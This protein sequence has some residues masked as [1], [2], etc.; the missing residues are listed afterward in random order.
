[1]NIGV[2]GTGIVG[3]TISAHLAGGGH[4]VVIGTR[5][6]AH[7]L[8]QSAPDAMGTPPFSAW[9]GSHA[10]VRLGTF[11]EAAAH[12]DVLINATVGH[13]SLNALAAAGGDALAGKVLLDIA[14]PLDFSHGMPPSLF[15]C[16][17]D[18][19]AEQ[20]QRAFPALKV[21]KTLNIVTASVMVNPSLVAGGD[22]HM[23]LCGN[24]AGA[25]EAVAGYLRDWFGWQHVLDLGDLSAARGMEMMLPVWLRLWGALQTPMFGYKIAR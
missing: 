17:T 9:H 4:S 14:N 20:I 10:Q 11:A 25:R 3:R 23:L 5:D 13:A 15:V 2:L 24:D 6:V 1:M 8:A 7:T 16:N 12:G 18:S 21:V 19:L 22:H